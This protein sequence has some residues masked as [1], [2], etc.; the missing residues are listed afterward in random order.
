MR[1]SN[2][3]VIILLIAK[4]DFALILT[5]ITGSGKSEFGN[6]LINKTV[7]TAQ[8]GLE[9]VTSGSKSF[10]AIIGGKCIKLID[11]PGFLDPSSPSS[12][13]EFS[14]FA[15]AIVDNGIN[16]V[17]LVINLRTRITNEDRTLLEKL[18][19]VEEMIPYT[20]L[21]FTHAKSYGYTST[22]Q[23]NNFEKNLFDTADSPKN[24]QCLIS[25]A[26]N[27][28]MLIESV[29][30]MEEGYHDKKSQELLQIL[31]SILNET[32]KPFMSAYSDAFNQSNAIKDQNRN[33]FIEMLATHIQNSKPSIA[34]NLS[35]VYWRRATQFF[36][37][38]CRS[39]S[40]AITFVTNIPRNITQWIRD[41]IFN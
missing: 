8:W 14:A 36:Q 32:N 34:Q 4:V 13:E 2:S 31:Q 18:L 10:T 3:H 21:I 22:E 30:P 26:K 37:Y 1:N 39:I 15:E 28:F 35:S 12:E 6:F 19:E 11:T 38:G 27:R 17:G 40:V 5:G 23:Q 33:Q 7:F 25:R 41:T 20:F 29:E 16:A 9:V 24:L